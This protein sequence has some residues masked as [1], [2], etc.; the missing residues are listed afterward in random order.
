MP[1]TKKQRGRPARPLPPRIDA[2]PEEL[3]RAVLSAGRPTTAVDDSKVYRC[4][5]CGQT[6]QWPATLYNDGRCEDCHTA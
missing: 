4:R 3:A 5:S 2:T 6:V 1:R